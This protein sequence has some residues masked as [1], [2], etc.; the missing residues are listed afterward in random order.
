MVT[1]VLRS[2]LNIAF[3]CYQ[4]RRNILNLQTA[5]HALEATH[6]FKILKRIFCPFLFI[7]GLFQTY[8]NTIL[9][10]INVKMS[11]QDTAL[12]FEPTTFRT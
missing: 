12:G 3:K 11:I 7:F 4:K 8:I 1:L 6:L 10:Q 2:N 9:Q 5:I